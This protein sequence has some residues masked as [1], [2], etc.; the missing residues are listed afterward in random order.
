MLNH[1]FA[2]IDRRRVVI[3]I[4]SVARSAKGTLA[5]AIIV[6]ALVSPASAAGGAI[7]QSQPTGNSRDFHHDLRLASNCTA[8]GVSC[9]EGGAQNPRTTSN[10]I[11]T[12][13]SVPGKARSSG[14]AVRCGAPDGLRGIK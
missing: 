12:N 7:A 10:E 11:S 5:A 2:I 1:I 14:R 4:Q 3:R 6:A 9:S 8:G 13:R